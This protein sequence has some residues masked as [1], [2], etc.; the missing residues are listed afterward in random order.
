ML[1]VILRMLLQAWRPGPVVLP[2]LPEADEDRAREEFLG[3]VRA[4]RHEE[5]KARE[6]GGFPE[7]ARRMLLKFAM[8]PATFLTDAYR[9][10]GLH[11]DEGKRAVDELVGNGLVRLHRLPRAGRGAQYVVVEVT[12][13]ALPELERAGIKKVV[14][15]LKGGFKHDVYGRLLR[16]DAERNG[17]RCFFERTLGKKTFDVVFEDKDSG[18]VGIEI[19]LTG[20]V[21]W[22]AQQVLKGLENVGLVEVVVATETRRF[23]DEIVKEI[24]R[25]D[26]GGISKGRVKARQLAEFF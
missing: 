21:S 6:A 1:P 5:E 9:E 20:S 19:C 23:G 11:P 18:L 22:N 4:F 8:E 12:E 25:L 14:P 13:R 26:S 3:S 10:L 2:K 24:S 17:L 7:S 15:V 16:K